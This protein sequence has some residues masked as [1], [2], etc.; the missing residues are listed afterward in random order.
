MDQNKSN[1]AFTRRKLLTGVAAGSA[2]AVGTF[3]FV[4][5]TYGETVRS[6]P[7]GGITPPRVSL[8]PAL[9]YPAPSEVALYLPSLSG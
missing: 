4:A 7:A 6:V 3:T 8:G 2:M 5:S 1:K 9:S